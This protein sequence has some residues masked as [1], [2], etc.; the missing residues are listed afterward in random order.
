MSQQYSYGMQGSGQYAPPQGGPPPPHAQAGQAHDYYQQASYPPPTNGGYDSYKPTGADPKMPLAPDGYQGERFA[1][2][3]PK[4]NDLIFAILFILVFL[5]YT[6]LSVYVLREYAISGVSGGIG[7]N[8]GGFSGTLNQHTAI[9]LSLSCGVALIFSALYLVLVRVATRAILEITL[10][11]SVLFSVGYAVYLWIEGM[12]SAA[13]MATI[14]AVLSVVSYFFMRKRIPLTRLLLKT[15]IDATK[16][17]PSVYLWALIGLVVQTLFSIWVSW[18]TI[19]IYQRFSP[20]GAA[21]GSSSS[22]GAVTGLIVFVVVA[23]YWISETIK[24]IF[25]TTVCAIFGTHFYSLDN[26][27]QRGSGIKAFGRSMTYSLGSIAFGSLIVAILDLIRG[28]VSIIQSTQA[29]EGDMV[30]AAIACVA[31]CI[32]GCIQY[33]IEFFNKYALINVSLYGNSYITAAKETWRLMKDRGITALINDS[34]VNILWTFGSVVVG[35]ICG[36]FAYVY[37]KQ[38]DP[39]AFNS[40]SSYYAVVLFFAIGLGSQIALTLGA[41]SIGAGVS[42]LFVTLAEDPQVMAQKEPELFEM[43]RRTYPQVAQAVA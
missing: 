35:I 34:L 27:R 11:L 26:K 39:S 31:G 42:T 20:S 1:P 23:F 5:G 6:G 21:S 13:I 24:G 32:I 19:A 43:I 16:V 8:T 37:I 22:S 18:T 10:A 38:T 29:S 30:G 17:Y 40:E 12:T 4:F 25:F 2:A 33:L 28:L 36:I 3:K 15:T 41:G 7:G 14:F 9:L